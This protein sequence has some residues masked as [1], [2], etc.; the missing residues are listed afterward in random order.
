MEFALIRHTRCDI[1]AG[2]CYG[3][4]DVPLASTAATDIDQTLARVPRVDLVFSSPSQRCQ[5]LAQALAHRDAC[6]V[7]TR[8][9]LR[10]LSFGAWEGLRWSDIL[11]ASSD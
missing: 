10:E 1:P 8:P 9:D 5:A 7:R 6:N 2:T 3:Q 4:L 11:R